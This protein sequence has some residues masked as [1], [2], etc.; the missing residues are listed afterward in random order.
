ML[1]DQLDPDVR[2]LWH[3][4]EA[5]GVQ[6]ILQATNVFRYLHG[7]HK[8]EYRTWS[9]ALLCIGSSLASDDPL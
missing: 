6:W 9:F 2:E 3:A 8:P 7:K 1:P 5:G 4:S